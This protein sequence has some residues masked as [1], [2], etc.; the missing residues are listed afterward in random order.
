MDRGSLVCGYRARVCSTSASAT[1]AFYT[2]GTI[3]A[4]GA[5]DERGG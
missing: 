5:G 3:Q 4:R 2:E 1:T